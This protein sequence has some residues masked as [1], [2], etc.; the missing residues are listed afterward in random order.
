M[1]RVRGRGSLDQAE[2]SR[3]W[4]QGLGYRFVGLGKVVAVVVVSPSLFPSQCRDV[5][6]RE[7]DGRI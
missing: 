6:V 3:I 4:D 7:G 5:A 1:Y 2:D